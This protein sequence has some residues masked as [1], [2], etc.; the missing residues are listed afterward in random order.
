MLDSYRDKQDKKG[1]V[2]LVVIS[3]LLLTPN[4]RHPTP[5]TCFSYLD[6][7][8]RDRAQR[9]KAPKVQGFVVIHVLYYK[10]TI[11][12]AGGMNEEGK[13]KKKD[14]GDRRIG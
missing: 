3:G 1:W 4:P 7:S 14:N 2:L 11:E 6:G 12:I 5:E 8:F 13:G 9:G 10:N